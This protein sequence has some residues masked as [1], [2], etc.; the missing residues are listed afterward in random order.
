MSI[1]K[2]RTA[3]PGTPSERAVNVEPELSQSSIFLSV[4]VL[5]E[6]EQFKRAKLIIIKKKIF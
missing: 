2:K 4:I 3:A 1:V 5:F 6:L